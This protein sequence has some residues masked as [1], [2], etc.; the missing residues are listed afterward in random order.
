MDE[1]KLTKQEWDDTGVFSV[2]I[3]FL[4][5]LGMLSAWLHR[6]PARR[7]AVHVSQERKGVAFCGICL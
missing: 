1:L 7:L 4:E 6:A 2:F 5:S 3:I